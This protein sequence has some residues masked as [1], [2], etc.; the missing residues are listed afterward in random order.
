MLY[1]WLSKLGSFLGTLNNGCR[2]ILGIQK[3][4]IILTTTHI[5]SL[6][7]LR[8]ILFVNICVRL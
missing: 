2:I 4:T 1:G 3:M 5:F 6:V 7:G 8:R